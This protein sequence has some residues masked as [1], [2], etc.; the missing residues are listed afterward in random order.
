MGEMR[1]GELKKND[2]VGGVLKGGFIVTSRR[3]KR[4]VT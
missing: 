4:R 3:R 2:A 1:G